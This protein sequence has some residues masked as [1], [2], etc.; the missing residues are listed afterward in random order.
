M[1]KLLISAIRF[2]QLCISPLF[3]SRCRFIPT[4]SEYFI[5]AVEKKGL[6]KGTWLGIK[7]LLSCH[8]FNPGGYD[9]VE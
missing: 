9:P 3:P 5:Q 8:P 2:Y 7:R 6:I 1:S 4:C